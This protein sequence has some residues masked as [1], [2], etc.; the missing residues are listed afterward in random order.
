MRV[1]TET[2]RFKQW[3]LILLA[4]FLVIL[5]SLTAVNE[6]SETGKAGSAVISLIMVIVIFG[7]LFS[8]K[9][10][11]RINAEGIYTEF[12]PLPI[13]QK[14]FK[15]NDISKCHVRK[16]SALTEYGGWGIKGFGKAKAY[17]V[18]GN[19]GIQIITT[20]GY[21]FLIGTQKPKEAQKVIERFLNKKH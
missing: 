16:Y 18:S 12:H 11:T 9:L 2:Q 20:E 5:T 15:W 17:N 1:F 7:L 21:K 3:W 13:F 8:L 19:K 6:Y 14:K 4:I 10:E